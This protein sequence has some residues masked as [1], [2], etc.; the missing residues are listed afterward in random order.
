MLRTNSKTS[1]LLK[2]MPPCSSQ[3]QLVVLRFPSSSV[4]AVNFEATVHVAAC[5]RPVIQTMGSK[6]P[7]E[8][9]GQ[10]PS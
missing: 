4:P 10:V 8:H 7:T 1:V 6:T 9:S 3:I 2:P 5:H